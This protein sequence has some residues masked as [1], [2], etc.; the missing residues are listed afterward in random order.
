MNNYV[1]YKDL[2]A[3]HPGYYVEDCFNDL[4]ISQLEFAQRMGTSPKTLSLLINGQISVSNDLAKKLSQ[5][6]GTSTQL[7]LNLQA[8][9]D[10]KMIEIEKAK[11]Y[12]N[13]KKTAYMIDYSYFVD[14]CGLSSTDDIKDKI[15]NLCGYL[16]VADL[17]IFLKEDFLVSYKVT[18]EE[19][20]P[21]N[22]LN[23]RVW[24]QVAINFSRKLDLKPYDNVLLK[25]SI[26]EFKEMKNKSPKECIDGI[27]DIFESCGV[28]FILLPHLKNSTVNGAVKWINNE[29]VILAME[30]SLLDSEDFWFILFHEIKHV[31]QQKIKTVFMNSCDGYSQ[32]Q[33]FEQEADAF[34]RKM[35]S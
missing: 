5:A 6:L 31:L 35:L 20:K 4:N 8:S 9:Y 25:S 14:N 2:I 32:N 19:L 30:E 10:E 16:N 12:Y 17:R 7:W 26:D 27:K 13:Q 1:E 34:A 18:T 29:K 23:N 15:A 22:I 24:L 28:A 21:V 11:D 33:K 3:F